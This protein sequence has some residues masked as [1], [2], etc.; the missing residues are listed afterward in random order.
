MSKR[1]LKMGD[2]MAEMGFPRLNA[3]L[4]MALTRGTQLQPSVIE[5]LEKWLAA[6]AM[7]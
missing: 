1:H 3:S 5:A 7:V 2:V 4:G 6:N